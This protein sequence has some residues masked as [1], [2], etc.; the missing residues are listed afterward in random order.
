MKSEQRDNKL[1]TF[2]EIKHD[3]H[4]HDIMTSLVCSA[5]C[6]CVCVS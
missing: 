1:I 3:R 5:K 2:R 4:T 6:W